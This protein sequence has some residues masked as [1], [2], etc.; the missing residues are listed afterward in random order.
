[1]RDLWAQKIY[2][3]EGFTK[4]D[5]LD[6]ARALDV[7]CGARKLPG[8]TG[9]DRLQLPG[10]DVVH[11]FNTTPWPFADGSF[12]LVLMNHS[13][14]HVGDVLA[15][16]SEVHRVLVPGGR[17]VIQVPYFRSIDAK[18]DPTHAHVFTSR[19]LDYVIQ[20]SALSHYRYSDRL[21]ATKGF[22]YGWPQS[23]RNSVTHAFKSFIASH[24][25]FYDQY[26]SL[27]APVPC[28]T[29]ELEAIKS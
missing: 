7:G 9:M 1:M 21:F 23:S 8:A 3:R 6:G 28:L 29:W 25:S 22:W 11:D 14:E 2:G 13:L 10:V 4:R 16:M 15:V 17:V 12:D 27:L 5:V 18:T 20:G 24:P 26:L 19:T